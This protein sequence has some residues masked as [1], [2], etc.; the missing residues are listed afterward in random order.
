VTAT[1]YPAPGTWSAA[2]FPSAIGLYKKGEGAPSD[3]DQQKAEKYFALIN[4]CVA[5]LIKD[6]L[7][8]WAQA[9]FN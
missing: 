2:P 8:K 3:F 6:T 9:G 1:P 5:N 4:A 7:N